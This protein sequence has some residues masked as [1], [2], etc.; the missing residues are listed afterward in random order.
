MVKN[1]SAVQETQVQ[2]LGW[3][4][5]LEKGMATH[6]SILAWRILWTEEPG[7]LQSTGFDDQGVCHQVSWSTRQMEEETASPETKEGGGSG[8]INFKNLSHSA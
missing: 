7:G 5:P 1:L 8:G 3:E 6:F 2:S 4:E